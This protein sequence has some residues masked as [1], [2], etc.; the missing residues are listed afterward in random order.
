MVKKK[1]KKEKKSKAQEKQTEKIEIVH[2]VVVDEPR[3]KPEEKP[4]SGNTMK[5]VFAAVIIIAIIMAYMILVP[6]NTFVPGKSVD[7]DTF[8]DLFAQKDNIIIFM[9][10]RGVSNA[11]IKQNIFQC[12]IDFA[13][14][15]GMGPKNVTYFSIGDDEQGC[16][17]PQG[18]RE[19]QYCFDELDN[20]ITIYV[21]EADETKY[22]NNGVVVGVSE[23]Y[24]VGLCGIHMLN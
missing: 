15:S 13:G 5:I 17:T 23:E 19:E 7:K 2:E 1:K 12:G 8:L 6:Y 14:S 9:D 20:A 10:V 4:A 22:Y 18:I 21:K 3:E 16:V 11:K 24:P